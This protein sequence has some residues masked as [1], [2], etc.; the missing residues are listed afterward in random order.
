MTRRL[1][2]RYCWLSGGSGYSPVALP[3]CFGPRVIGCE[4][5]GSELFRFRH[6]KLF[7]YRFVEVPDRVQVTRVNWLSIHGESFVGP[8]LGDDGANRVCVV[9]HSL[10]CALNLA[11]R[12]QPNLL[13]QGT[14]PEMNVVDTLS[15]SP[16]I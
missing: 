12:K 4:L 11:I 1:A 13:V 3:T 2:A 6:A 7:P 9:H 16:W 10:C 14:H 8:L 15:L 5:Q